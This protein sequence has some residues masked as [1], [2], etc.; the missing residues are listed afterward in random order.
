MR[1]FKGV[2]SL[3]YLCLAVNVDDL[4]DDI[5]GLVVVCPLLERYDSSDDDS[6]ELY[7]DKYSDEIITVFCAIRIKTYSLIAFIRTL[8]PSIIASL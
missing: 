2:S 7:E 1:F 8:S 5:T 6:N 4:L 3:S